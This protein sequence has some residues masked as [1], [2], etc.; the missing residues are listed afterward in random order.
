MPVE[1]KSGTGGTLRS[2]HLMLGAYPHCAD[3]VVLYSGTWSRLPEQR[4]TFVPLYYAGS[5]GD[6]RPDIV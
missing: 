2:L 6:P 1:V 3:G 5:I 4:L